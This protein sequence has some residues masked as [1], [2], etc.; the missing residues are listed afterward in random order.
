MTEPTY[1]KGCAISS[2]LHL[3]HTRWL[4][5]SG[6]LPGLY[7][8]PQSVSVSPPNLDSITGDLGRFWN[9][10]VRITAFLLSFKNA[11][12][13][14]AFELSHQFLIE[15][16]SLQNPARSLTGQH[17][18]YQHYLWDINNLVREYPSSSIYVKRCLSPWV[19]TDLKLDSPQVNHMCL[20]RYVGHLRR[21]DQECQDDIH[22]ETGSLIGLS[23]L[24]TQWVQGSSCLHPRVLGLYIA[25]TT[26]LVFKNVSSGDET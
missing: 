11:G 14:W 15:S 12:D 23:R 25:H 16:L 21:H 24:A 4:F 26:M 9:L 18:I 1:W 2:V 5:L 19:L 10:I 22:P 8:V 20:Y 7:S 17:N 13:F 6:N 3:A